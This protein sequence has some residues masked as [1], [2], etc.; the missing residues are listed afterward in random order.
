MLDIGIRLLDEGELQ[1][2]PGM[3]E[4]LPVFIYHARMIAAAMFNRSNIQRKYSG[5]KTKIALIMVEG[6]FLCI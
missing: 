2:K 4:A 3:H 5:N 1:K 6:S